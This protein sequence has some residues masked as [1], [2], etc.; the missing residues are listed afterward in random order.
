MA[1]SV[2]NDHILYLPVIR[3]LFKQI[4]LVFLVP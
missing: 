3:N 2:E 4:R 1:A